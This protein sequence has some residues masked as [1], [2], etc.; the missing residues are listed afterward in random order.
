[1]TAKEG[2]LGYEFTAKYKNQFPALGNSNNGS[3]F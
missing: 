3:D 2:K 1:M